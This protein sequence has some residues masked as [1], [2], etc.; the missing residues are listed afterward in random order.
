MPEKK[1][2]VISK[3][4]RIDR[5]YPNDLKTHFVSNF[6]I[7]TQPDHFVLTFFEVWPPAIVGSSEEKKAALDGL[8]SV[9][10]KCVARIVVTPARMQELAKLIQENV[11][12]HD[13]VKTNES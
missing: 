4:V 9:E 6:V 11:R 3:T 8:Q 5:V 7:Q 2:E 13:S 12:H 10:A 1:P